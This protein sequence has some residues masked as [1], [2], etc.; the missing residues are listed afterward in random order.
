MIHHS[1]DREEKPGN[2][3]KVKGFSD[4]ESMLLNGIDPDEVDGTTPASDAVI[5]EA[6]RAV[7]E[8]PAPRQ[9]R[10]R[11][12]RTSQRSAPERAEYGDDDNDLDD[13]ESLEYV[14]DDGDDNAEEQQPSRRRQDEQAGNWVDD[15]A[16]DLGLSY[17]LTEDQL[18]QFGSREAL[19]Q[20]IAA[21]NARRSPL[22][23]QTSQFGLPQFQQ[24]GLGYA[25][26]QS[27]WFLGPQQQAQQPIQQVQQPA[28]E[29]PQEEKAGF[30]DGL[31]DV[32]HFKKVYAENFDETTANLLSEQLQFIR[33]QQALMKGMQDDI[34]AQKRLHLQQQQNEAINAF[35]DACDSLNPQLFGRSIDSRGNLVTLGK[36]ELANREKLGAAINQWVIPQIFAQQQ[37]NGLAEPVIPAFHVLARRA[38]AFAFGNDPTIAGTPARREALISQGGRRRS[39]GSGAGNASSR[40][41]AK[42]ESGP[43]TEESEVQALLNDPA[44]NA[45][46]DGGRY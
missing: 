33:D 9:V 23:Q 17:G 32:D 40:R 7:R 29:E 16:I 25:Q 30:K 41:S 8:A 12:Q 34:Q 31:I 5:D 26:Q 6:E 10:E 24:P 15:E 44:V 13:S 35:H 36:A 3:P 37:A 45:A 2:S 18:E 21:Y 42:R 27:P 28:K 43:I 38:M 46:W 1:Q 19:D 22:G 20:A 4:R 11:P 39:P 14:D